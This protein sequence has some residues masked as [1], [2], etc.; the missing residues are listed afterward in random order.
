MGVE[1]GCHRHLLQVDRWCHHHQHQHPEV[2]TTG[3]ALGGQSRQNLGEVVHQG[4]RPLSN[5]KPTSLS[6]REGGGK[7]ILLLQMQICAR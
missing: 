5:Y 2:L 1:D 7:E 6:Q 3:P 4:L